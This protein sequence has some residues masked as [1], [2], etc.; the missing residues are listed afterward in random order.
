M[1]VYGI[2]AQNPTVCF[3]SRSRVVTVF[4]EFKMQLCKSVCVL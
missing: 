4:E 1:G 2:L 3:G